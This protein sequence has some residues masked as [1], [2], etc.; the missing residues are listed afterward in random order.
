MEARA[1][2]EAHYRAFDANDVGG[3]LAC[4]AEGVEHHVN[5]GG[6]RRGRDAFRSFSDHMARCYRATVE[7]QDARR[8]AAEFVVSGTYLAEGLPPARGQAY[9]L[10]AAAFFALGDGRIARVT[11]YY[12]LRDW[13]AQVS[14]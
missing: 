4:P 9:R 7:D 2:L 5:Q 3:M 13:I 8:G 1:L 11:T 10:P 12:N 6:E 14:R